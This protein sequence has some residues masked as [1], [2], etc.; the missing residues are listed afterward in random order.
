MVTRHAAGRHSLR[1]RGAGNLPNRQVAKTAKDEEGWTEPE[2][3][4]GFSFAVWM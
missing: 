4:A 1:R 3:W 2:S